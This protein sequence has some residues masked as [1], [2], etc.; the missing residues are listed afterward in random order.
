[1][2]L[3]GLLLGT[4]VHYGANGPRRGYPSPGS[5][6]AEYDAHVGET[7]FLLAEVAEI[8]DGSATLRVRGTGSPYELRAVGLAPPITPGALIQVYGELGADRTV[9][10]S[11]AVVVN[12]SRTAELTKY[13]L[14]ALGAALA[15]ALFFWYW[16]VDLASLGF[17]VRRDG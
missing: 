17:E 5:I 14:S 1:V 2:V 4:F 16:R 10:V 15:L 8:D 11:N 6:D 3:V 7:V 13:G 12:P 9:A